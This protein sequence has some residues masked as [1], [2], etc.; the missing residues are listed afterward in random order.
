MECIDESQVFC[1][2]F[3]GRGEVYCRSTSRERTL[4]EHE[5]LKLYNCDCPFKGATHRAAVFPSGLSAIGTVMS[6]HLLPYAAEKSN[7]I[8]LGD[9]LYC[10]V[11]RT[12]K[13]LCGANPGRMEVVTVDVTDKAALLGLFKKRGRQIRLFHFEMCTNPSGKIIDWSI[14]PELR[15]LAP[16]CTFVCDNT[17]LSGG[18]GFNPLLHGADVVVESLTKHLSGG[19]CIGGVALGRTE[20]MKPVLAQVKILGLFVPADRCRVFAKALTECPQRIAT[21]SETAWRVAKKLEADPR[22]GRVMHPFLPSHPSHVLAVRYLDS[23][24]GPSV[25]W[26]FVPVRKREV[27][28][29]IDYRKRSTGPLQFLTSYGGPGSRFHSWPK[30]RPEDAYEQ[31]HNVATEKG[32]DGSLLTL[33]TRT[34]EGWVRF[35]WPRPAEDSGGKEGSETMREKSGEPE[36]PRI[37]TWLRLSTGYLEPAETT[38]AALD[39]VLDEL[40]GPLGE[41][42]EEGEGQRRGGGEGEETA[43]A[44]DAEPIGVLQSHAA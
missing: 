22:V 34:I 41:A 38:L 16:T 44:G 13:N 28:K 7:V 9:E 23:C 3:K 10:D 26:F 1:P 29:V 21:T 6:A 14:L 42:N 4:L 40:L 27:E 35:L 31:R 8:V 39:E 20:V 11:A 19:E 25:V 43:A 12:A 30:E 24:K 37:G 5:Y 33:L 32:T 36:Q 17:W 2:R 15:L 18:S